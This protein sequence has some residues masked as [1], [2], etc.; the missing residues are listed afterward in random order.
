MSTVVD[1]AMGVVVPLHAH[2]G[3]RSV[4]V[5]Y[6]HE[7]TSREALLMALGA[8]T[9]GSIAGLT[10]FNFTDVGL[11]EGIKTLWKKQPPLA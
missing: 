4:I 8:F 7:R 3:M 10:F 9:I 2:I 11:T 5:D 1:V 6:I